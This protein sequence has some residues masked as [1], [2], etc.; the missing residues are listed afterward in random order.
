MTGE[1][2]EQVVP[3]VDLAHQHRPLA[4]ELRAAFNRVLDSGAFILGEEVEQFEAEFA[5]F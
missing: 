5:S 2:L 3:F 4:P 1:V